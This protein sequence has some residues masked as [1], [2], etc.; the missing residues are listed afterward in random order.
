MSSASK[1]KTK[2]KKK[3]GKK[4]N[5]SGRKKI[6]R[7]YSAAKMSAAVAAVKTKGMGV[8]AA[9]KNFPQCDEALISKEVSNSNRNEVS[10]DVNTSFDIVT[11]CQLDHLDDYIPGSIDNLSE[12][13]EPILENTTSNQNFLS[14]LNITP[15][16]NR[17]SSFVD[18]IQ[19]VDYL[20]REIRGVLKE[21]FPT[22]MDEPSTPGCPSRDSEDQQAVQVITTNENTPLPIEDQ[23]SSSGN[24]QSL[25]E[26]L[27]HER[28]SETAHHEPKSPPVTSSLIPSPFKKHLFFPSKISPCSGRRRKPADVMPG[29][30]SS[31]DFRAYMK[32]KEVKKQQEV[33]EKQR[34]KEEREK[35]KAVKQTKQA[36]QKQKRVAKKIMP[37][38]SMEEQEQDESDSDE[39]GAA[40]EERPIAFNKIWKFGRF[41]HNVK[42]LKSNHILEIDELTEKIEDAYGSNPVQDRNY[43]FWLRDINRSLVGK[44]AILFTSDFP[45]KGF[46]ERGHIPGVF[47]TIKFGA[48]LTESTTASHLADRGTIEY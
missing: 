45:Q 14:E 43:Q 34:K 12:L 16:S 29:A 46:V 35:L 22:T 19:H 23:P 4:G 24:Y 40:L 26:L 13:N 6:R 10:N 18:L 33:A 37:N 36:G 25:N 3:T 9:S 48:S 17:S 21:D 15:S 7:Q 42:P 32:R 8:R 44:N 1:N 39:D 38:N 28:P 27:Q 41:F 47:A 31:D 2:T 5:E 11:A 20:T 30:I